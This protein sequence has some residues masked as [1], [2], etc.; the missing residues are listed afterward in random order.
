MAHWQGER[1]KRGGERNC[2]VRDGRA[3]TLAFM[4]RRN[5]QIAL[6]QLFAVRRQTQVRCLCPRRHRVSRIQSACR[7][8]HTGPLFESRVEGEA[9]ERN[10]GRWR[11]VIIR[12]S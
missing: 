5:L 11:S 9:E 10:G 12:Q 6:V 2:T 8:T 4:A 7:H 1:R 3:P